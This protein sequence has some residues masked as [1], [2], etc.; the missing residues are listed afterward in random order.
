MRDLVPEKTLKSQ[1]NLA[2]WHCHVKQLCSVSPV[3]IEA[4]AAVQG[5]DNLAL[6]GLCLP[7]Q[8]DNLATIFDLPV[9]TIFQ[10]E[11]DKL[12]HGVQIDSVVNFSLLSG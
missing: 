9:T 8:S 11:S 1:I 6:S 4:G 3:H 5:S 2:K 12:T 7:E 10:H